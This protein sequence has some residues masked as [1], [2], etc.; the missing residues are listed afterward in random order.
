MSRFGTTATLLFACLVLS[1]SSCGKKGPLR[2][3]ADEKP[4]APANATAPA[5]PLPAA[6]VDVSS[7]ALVPSAP[8]GLEAFVAE[9]RVI[10]FWNESPEIRVGGYEIYRAKEDGGFEVIG[11]TATPAFTDMGSLTEKRIY[12]IKVLG[13]RSEG[14]FSE[15]VEVSP[16]K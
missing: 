5:G 13:P 7:D 11:R 12:R 6:P 2:L 10:L 8:T 16:K 4:T 1:L 3:P 15:T 14:S 9:D